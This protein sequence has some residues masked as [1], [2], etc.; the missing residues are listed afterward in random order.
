MVALQLVGRLR[1][2]IDEEIGARA[3]AGPAHVPADHHARPRLARWGWGAPS[4]R[5]TGR[6]PRR[7]P[8]GQP[9]DLLDAVELALLARAGRA[10]ERRHTAVEGDK[11][12]L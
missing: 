4:G 12:N 9:E 5:F 3:A 7:W 2:Q 1:I 6:V 10:R 11:N 8:L